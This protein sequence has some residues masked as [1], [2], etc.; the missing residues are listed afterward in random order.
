[1]S[2]PGR[3]LVNISVSLAGSLGPELRNIALIDET[4]PLSCILRDMVV[5]S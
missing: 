4:R 3:R 2:D 1:M 5:V